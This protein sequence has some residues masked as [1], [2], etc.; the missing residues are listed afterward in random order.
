MTKECDNTRYLTDLFGEENVY[1]AGDC[2]YVFTI[3]D[4]RESIDCFEPRG[5]LYDNSGY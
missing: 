4:G 3:K 2:S 1:Y 5:Y